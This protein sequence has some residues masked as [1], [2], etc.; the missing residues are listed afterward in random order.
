MTYEQKAARL[1][2][3]A[4]STRRCF[5]CGFCTT[6]HAKALAHFGDHDE[7]MALC[8]WWTDSTDAERV[9]ALQDAIE[10]R[11]AARAGEA[12]AVE[13]LRDVFTD[14]RAD[15]ED[16]RADLEDRNPEDYARHGLVEPGYCEALQ[17]V[18][19]GLEAVL[20]SLSQ[21]ALDWLAQ[22]EREAAAKELEGVWNRWC[23]DESY[24]TSI[25][26]LWWFVYDRAAALRAGKV[27]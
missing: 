27:N 5:H 1:E 11:D 4:E 2:H 19:D 6:N 12:R 7:E 20:D 24:D 14:L 23:R 26:G 17:D 22:R 16:L 21:P 3:M 18:T 15:R 9:Q 25:W 13:A 10:E 8:R